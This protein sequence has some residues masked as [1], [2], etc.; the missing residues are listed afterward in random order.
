MDA[1][2][3]LAD[4][5][6]SVIDEVYGVLLEKQAYLFEYEASGFILGLD[7]AEFTAGAGV[8]ICLVREGISAT[9]LDTV[10]A[11]ARIDPDDH[12]EYEIRQALYA[13]NKW[14]AIRRVDTTGSGGVDQFVIDW[15]ISF[16]PKSKGGIPHSAG[17]GWK[18][19]IINRTSGTLTTGAIIVTNRI[20]ERFAY[21][22]F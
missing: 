16:K 21:G 18:L 6:V 5:G 17:K 7:D 20:Y 22:G 8:T 19:L 11:G 12:G 1:L 9:D 15:E 13:V 10:L 14:R 3:T 2:G 4:N